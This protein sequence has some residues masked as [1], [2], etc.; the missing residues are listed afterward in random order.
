MNHER[1]YGVDLLRLVLM[2][3]VCMLHTLGQGGILTACQEGTGAYNVF[4][5]ME[6]M[7]FCAVDAFAIITG[8]MAVDKPQK[9]E[10]LTNMW[11]QAFFYSFVLTL[12]FTI[13][14]VNQTWERT[15]M[16]A[17][18]LPV[19]HGKFWYFTS[20]FVLFFAIPI[21]KKYLFTVDEHTAKIALIILFVLFSC[22]ETLLRPFYTYSGY[23]PIWL[24]VL[25]CLGALA[26]R[27]KVFEQKKT[28]TLVLIWAVCIFASWGLYALLGSMML[29]DY[30]SPTIVLS[31]FIMVVLFSRLKLKGTMISKL[32]PLALGIYFFQQNQ[33]IWNDFL[34]NAFSF[35]AQEKL[36]VGALY[37]FAFAAL[38]FVSGMI[39]EFIRSKLAKAL[40]IPALSRAIVNAAGAV[41]NK[42][43]ALLK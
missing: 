25:Y 38:I 26:K 2:Y 41:L 42:A 30:V 21:L 37:A 23:S 36:I 18:A 19:S 24:I 6:T 43:A 16:L 40:K 15:D 22:I 33:V 1:N 32:S 11:F 3:M 34:L 29:I 12:L 4:W 39:V 5:F 8:Y 9:Y 10:K 20:Y 27:A 35:A 28:L 7:S 13:A 31:G 14:G 17:C